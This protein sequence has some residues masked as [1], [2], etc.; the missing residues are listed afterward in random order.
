MI[1]TS[2]QERVISLS[3]TVLNSL[4][5]FSNERVQKNLIDLLRQSSYALRFMKTLQSIL[6]STWNEMQSGTNTRVARQVFLQGQV[7][8]RED[9]RLYLRA[10][11]QI[12]LNSTVR[13][14]LN[15]I[16]LMC[17]NCFSDFQNFL[18]QQGEGVLTSLNSVNVLYAT[19]RL[20]IA[21]AQNEIDFMTPQ[22]TEFLVPQ[23]L[24]TCIDFCYGPC[25]E[26]QMLFV[27]WKRL[28]FVLNLILQQTF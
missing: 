6:S 26:N 12:S 1:A 14:T 17:D 18:R 19:G 8:A 3:I 11:K 7:G 10:R 9:L 4:L 23:I 13:S 16:Q 21:V 15:L 5:K 25:S 27:S 28:L 22:K 20:L 2:S 24:R